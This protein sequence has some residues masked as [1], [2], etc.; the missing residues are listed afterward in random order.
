MRKM[1]HKFGNAAINK[2]PE[3]CSVHICIAVLKHTIFLRTL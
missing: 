1:Q 3:A 2:I